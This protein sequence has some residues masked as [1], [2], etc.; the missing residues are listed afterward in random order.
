MPAQGFTAFNKSCSASATYGL[1]LRNAILE[2]LFA[3]DCAP[4]LESHLRFLGFMTSRIASHL[5]LLFENCR[6]RP[7]IPIHKIKASR[8][9]GVKNSGH[10]L[11]SHAELSASYV[12]PEQWFFGRQQSRDAPFGRIWS[13]E[14]DRPGETVG[15]PDLVPGHSGCKVAPSSSTELAERHRSRPARRM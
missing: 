10:R 13:P 1:T 4:F 6:R 3:L 12:V 15:G 7:I 9:R 2:Q 8:W 14:L 11:N 5:V